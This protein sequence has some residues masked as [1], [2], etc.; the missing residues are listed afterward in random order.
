ML[1]EEQLRLG[2]ETLIRYRIL[3]MVGFCRLPPGTADRDSLREAVARNAEN[4]RLPWLADSLNPLM[5][6]LSR[7]EA[8]VAGLP[9]LGDDTLCRL[10]GRNLVLAYEGL[11]L[12]TASVLTA[13]VL[14]DGF[15]LVLPNGEDVMVL[16]EL[17]AWPDI[18]HVRE[19]IA[20]AGRELQLREQEV[21]G[22]EGRSGEAPGSLTNAKWRRFAAAL[23][24][25]GALQAL[26]QQVPSEAELLLEATQAVQKF[27]MPPW[28]GMPRV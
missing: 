21:A 2:F 13:D 1:P 10:K 24:R 28:V 9:K 17:R 11:G 26:V 3:L 16:A 12:S 4:V 18:T 22:L 8:F 15:E 25:K 27:S 6:D 23:V 7:V 20:A 14:S 19:Q 5:L